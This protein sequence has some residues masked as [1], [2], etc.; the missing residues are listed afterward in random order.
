MSTVEHSPLQLAISGR[1]ANGFK[2]KRGEGRVSFGS[3]DERKNIFCDKGTYIV[4]NRSMMARWPGVPFYDDG[5]TSRNGGCSLGISGTLVADD[6][7]ASICVRSNVSKIGRIFSPA[8]GLR[9]ISLVWVF[10]NEIPGVT[11]TS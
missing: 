10:S 8:N 7:A 3:H 11:I 1:S 5:T 2:K 4:N 9:G 6:I